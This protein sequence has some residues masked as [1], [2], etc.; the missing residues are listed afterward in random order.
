MT[1]AT[2]ATSAS[3]ALLV[4]LALGGLLVVLDTTV[5]VVALPVL[6]HELDAD[7]PIVQWVTTGYL[8]GIVAVLPTVAW[9]IGR[10]TARTVFIA[11]VVGFTVASVLAALCWN[12]ES[13]IVFRIL[14]GV[15]GGLIGPASQ[16]IALGASDPERRGRV[17]S[18]LGIP[19][20]FGPLAGP[21]LAGSI[22]DNAT[23]RLIFAINVPIG[24]AV[25]LLAARL[26]PRTARASPP[27]LDRVG[28]AL[29]PTGSLLLVLALTV[30]AGHGPTAPA[31]AAALAGPGALAAFS[32]RALRIEHPLLNLRL[33]RIR[34]VATGTVIATTFGAAYF[35]S[36]ILLP[37]YV[38]AVRGDAA[39]VAGALAIPQALAVGITMQIATRLTDRAPARRIIATALSIG[40]TGMIIL[41]AAIATNAPYPVLIAG[42]VALGI[43]SGGT[44][45]PAMTTATRSLSTSELP[46]GTTLLGLAQQLAASMGIAL[47]T[48][49]LVTG[50]G[51]VPIPYGAGLDRLVALSDT[52]RA[53]WLHE[54]GPAVA[55]AYIPSACLVLVALTVASIWLGRRT[56]PP[57]NQ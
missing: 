22:I 27:F 18:I 24:A 48:L 53:R 16:T 38:Q 40:L 7:L 39:T 20:L 31:I 37:L 9:L 36:A 30:M 10:L 2:A 45:L 55:Q 14:Q 47:T 32:I 33:L 50:L 25:I 28:L 3:R 52:D 5:T 15:A 17:M 57:H 6:T 35:G 4:P 11:A 42:T 23:W 41:A 43:G 51:A 34:S 13:L 44:I 12:I 56:R 54:L 26:I 46:W 49:V 8:L 21:L 19:V 29:L 1:T